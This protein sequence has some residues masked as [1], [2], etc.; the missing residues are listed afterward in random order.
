MDNGFQVRVV[1]INDVAGY[2]VDRRSIHDIEPLAPTEQRC[3]RRSEER[4]ERSNGGS[5]PDTSTP[6]Y[7][8]LFMH[9]RA[10][11]SRHGQKPVP[12]GFLSRTDQ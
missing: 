8:M 7:G 4:G 5:T 10:K 3:L 1:A 9:T 12:G 11:K 6:A 2:A